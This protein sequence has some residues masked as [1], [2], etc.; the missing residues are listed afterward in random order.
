MDAD[1]SQIVNEFTAFAVRYSAD[2]VG[3]LLTL[4]IGWLVA[5]WAGRAVRAG[6][7]RAGRLDETLKAPI[8]GSVRYTVLVLVLVAVLAQFG[9]QIASILAILGAAGLAVG[10]ALQGTLSNV[11]A[12][13]MLLTLR[14]FR[15]GDYI[16]A[17][18][19]AGTVVEVGLFTSEL[20]TYD[21][22]Y[23][24]VPNSSLWNRPI[25]NYSRLPTRRLDVTVGV[26]YETEVE[27][28]LDVLLDELRSD[29]R[30][31]DD[32]A[33]QVMVTALAHSAVNVNL[34]CWAN[35]GDYWDLLFHLNRRA[36][37]R[38]DA[39]GIAI[40]YPQRDIH[41]KAGALASPAPA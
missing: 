10:L 25:K 39:E 19:L 14:P 7:D 38:L 2:V 32:P 21:G 1:A 16:D 31:L 15:A 17:D 8:A 3:A 40:P 23:L 35:A 28:A 26:S 34:R 30:V 18:G 20:H 9:I 37:E 4:V 24:M 12:G 29:P 5:G 11:A 27:R 41:I 36:K 13:M 22:V 6:L 33:P